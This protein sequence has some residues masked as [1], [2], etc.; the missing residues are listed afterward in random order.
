[1]R[2]NTKVFLI[3]F[4]SAIL[5]AITGSVLEARGALSWLGFKENRVMAIFGFTMFCLISLSIVPL[6]IKFFVT[7]QIKIGNTELF[8]VKWLQAHEVGTVIG[9][10][11]F[12]SPHRIM[13]VH[14]FSYKGWNVRIEDSQQETH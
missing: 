13:H 12:L 11:I 4:I 7:M 9:F 6:A 2:I 10:W 1:M 14:S 8:L 3:I 5:I